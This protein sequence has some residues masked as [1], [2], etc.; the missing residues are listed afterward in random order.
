MTVV[1]SGYKRQPNDLYQTEEWAT[2]ALLKHINIVNA[3][4]WEPS[5]GNHKIADVIN[6]ESMY[7]HFTSDIETYDR[8]HSFHFDFFADTESVIRLWDRETWTKCDWIITNPP[9]GEGNRLAVKY[10]ELALERADN[11]ALLL[12]AKFDFDKTRQ[13][14]FK[15]NPRF[16]KKIALLDRIQWF[17]GATT[18]T[19]DHAWYVW[20]KVKSTAE[21]YSTNNTPIMYW[22]G[23]Q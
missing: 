2:R 23:K 11:V 1:D 7:R 6:K 3:N 4:V 18:G 5:A 13:H 10:A 16:S 8:K 9:Y 15:D 20:Q 14:L 22:E 17:P 12:T 21:H 19:E